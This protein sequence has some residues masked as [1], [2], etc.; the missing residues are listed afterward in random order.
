MLERTSRRV[1]I[2]ALMVDDELGH[3]SAAG[4]A[5]KALVEELAEREIHVV[6]ASSAEDGHAVI[7]SDSAIHAI[8]L[9]WDLGLPDDEATPDT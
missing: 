2:R 7:S 6:E 1:Q 5:A 4:R 3:A 8:L 9:D